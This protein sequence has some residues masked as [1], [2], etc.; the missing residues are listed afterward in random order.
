MTIELFFDGSC[1][2]H[3]ETKPMGIGLAVYFD[4]EYQ[5]DL[6]RAIKEEQGW[7][8]DRS[9]NNIAEWIGCVEAMKMAY[10]LK[11]EYPDAKF[12]VYSDSQIIAR[13]Y[14]GLYTIKNL[15]FVKYCAAARRYGHRIVREVEW[16]PREKNQQ[17]DKLSKEGV[18]LKSLPTSKTLQDDR[19]SSIQ[20][21]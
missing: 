6:S 4:K 9:T 3:L 16:I 11:K 15:E 5:A 1:N 20:T 17:A 21:T 14:N 2:N 10:E 7:Q 18:N 8:G 19:S 13:Q 12:K